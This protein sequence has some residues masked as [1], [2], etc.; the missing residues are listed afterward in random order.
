[1][2]L[3][4]LLIYTKFFL[5]NIC[6]AFP[7]L[8]Y[9]SRIFDESINRRQ[10][11]DSYLIGTNT[12]GNSALLSFDVLIGLALAAR[13]KKVIYVLCDGALSACQM[14]EISSFKPVAIARGIHQQSICKTCFPPAYKFLKQLGFEVLLLSEYDSASKLSIIEKDQLKQHSQAGFLRYIAKGSIESATKD[15]LQILKYFEES[16]HKTFNAYKN[17]ILKY[18][19]TKIILHHGIYIPQGSALAA[20]LA[21]SVP[22]ITWCVSYRKA[23]VML[24]HGNSYHITMPK[25]KIG[26]FAQNKLTKHQNKQLQKYLASREIGT[27]D[28]ISFSKKNPKGNIAFKNL[29][30]STLKPT[31]LLLTNVTWDANLHFDADIFENMTEWIFETIKI[32]KSLP[33]KQLIIRV[34]PAETSGTI[35]SREFIKEMVENHFPTLPS[36]VIL[37]GPD[38]KLVDTY[39]LINNSDIAIVYGT[40]AAAE[41][42][43]RGKPVIVVGS[44]WVRSKGFTF[45]PSSYDGYA[46]LLKKKTN[47]IQMTKIQKQLAKRY[48]YYLFFERMITLKHLIPKK[49]LTPFV[50]AKDIK[51][52]KDLRNDENLN[53]ITD[54]IISGEPFK[55]AVNYDEQ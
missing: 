49:L 8:K 29:R 55:T 37:I 46:E 11:A 26:D 43:A 15:E 4:S 45:D 34:H 6:G 39:T 22:V 12:G 47:S 53:A 38:D 31:Y 48:A 36:N 50:L 9:G 41:I 1:M 18:S 3:S 32:F 14:C 23:S 16:A 35:R 10:C 5:R 52:I 40:K 17:I 20:A 27:N 2:P 21:K 7:S 28:W 30:L 42:A 51:T 44:A 54:S 25:E 24:A 33:S 13:G 19:P